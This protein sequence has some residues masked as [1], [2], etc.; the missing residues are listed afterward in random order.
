MVYQRP[1]AWLLEPSEPLTRVEYRNLP[2]KVRVQDRHRYEGT[3][4]RILEGYARLERR[5]GSLIAPNAALRSFRAESGETGEQLA[6]RVRKKLG[7]AS[8]L[9]VPNMVSVVEQFG[10]RTIELSTSLSID[11]FAGKL[12]DEFVI[13]INPEVSSD[14]I[15][16]N[17][18]HEL[19]HIL[20][21]DCE[22]SDGLDR[23]QKESRVFE[24]G[25]CLLLPPDQ[26]RLAFEGRS[27]IRLRQFKE[28]FGIAMSA[29]IYR[30]E[31]TGV[32]D[33]RTAKSLWIE[34]A[35]RGWRANEPGVVW[36]DRAIRFEE[37][38]ETARNSEHRLTWRDLESVT[39]VSAAELQERVAAANNPIESNAGKEG[40]GP[41]TLKIR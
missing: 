29:M 18:G 23:K 31:K 3:A 24:F 26:L 27:G 12:G 5:I 15:R 6:S 32:L 38:L 17:L 11:G 22:A 34:F 28:R 4:K 37:L 16:L 35:R 7:I 2:S 14:R 41:T 40:E 8:H 21:R 30:A 39:G 1:L 25:S 36:R 10:I 13:V 19:G 33:T 9:P 20:F